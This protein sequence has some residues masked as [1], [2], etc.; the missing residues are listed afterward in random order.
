MTLPMDSIPAAPIPQKARA[1][2]KL[3]ILPANAHQAVVAVKRRRPATYSG[4]R[5]KVSESRPMSGWSDVEVSRKAVE[6]HDAELEA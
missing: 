3:P 4:L 2:M 6:S 5:P 1:A